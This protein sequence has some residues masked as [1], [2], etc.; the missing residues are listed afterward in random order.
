MGNSWNS[1]DLPRSSREPGKEVVVLHTRRTG[2][3]SALQL[4]QSR[5][6]TLEPYPR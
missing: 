5:H 3:Q 1:R 4:I 2:T 6:A